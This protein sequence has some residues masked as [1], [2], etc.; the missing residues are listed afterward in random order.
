MSFL[1]F[2]PLEGRAMPT[3]DHLDAL[4]LHD[5]AYSKT[6]NYCPDV[7]LWQWVGCV[8]STCED[9]TRGAFIR[10]A[11]YWEKL[12]EHGAEYGLGYWLADPPREA[13]LRRT[14]QLGGYWVTLAGGERWLVP[15]LRPYA[16]TLELGFF[17]PC[18]DPDGMDER[19]ERLYRLAMRQTFGR[20][21]IEDEPLCAS[22]EERDETILRAL[23]LN[24]AAP[25]Q[26][27]RSLNILEPET[28][29]HCLAAMFD[30]GTLARE[31]HLAAT[32]ELERIEEEESANV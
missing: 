21:P 32:R 5:L 16:Q 8:V 28:V 1:Y 13:E 17:P 22:T 6:L 7:Q 12:G 4:G 23:A 10:R 27:L 11:Q 26:A 29:P 20:E 18:A 19:V 30:L 3:R 14:Q 31:L 24:Y 9:A 25:W 15:T 2:I